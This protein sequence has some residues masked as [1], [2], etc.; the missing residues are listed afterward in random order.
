MDPLFWNSRCFKFSCTLCTM[1]LKH[2]G[3]LLP[4][5]CCSRTTLELAATV[6]PTAQ[7]GK[8]ISITKIFYWSIE[9]KNHEFVG[10]NRPTDFKILQFSI[11]LFE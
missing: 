6:R 3:V 4:L 10:T 1:E 9:P 5:A 2:L 8:V 11:D 7:K